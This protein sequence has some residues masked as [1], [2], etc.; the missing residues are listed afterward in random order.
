MED[1]FSEFLNDSLS[2]MIQMISSKEEII[3]SFSRSNLRNI[4]NDLRHIFMCASL[5]NKLQSS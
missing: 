4:M 2:S 5:S 3:F 1:F